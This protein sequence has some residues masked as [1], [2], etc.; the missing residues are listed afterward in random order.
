[1][2][3]PPSAK[4]NAPGASPGPVRTVI[5]WACATVATLVLAGLVVGRLASDRWQAT[6]YLH[7][8]PGV[9]ALATCAVALILSGAMRPGIRGS[10]GPGRSGGSRAL[11]RLRGALCGVLILGAAWIVL[12]EWHVLNA[13]RARGAPGPRISLVHFNASG[14]PAPA[15]PGGVLDLEPDVVVFTNLTH[16]AALPAV[17]QALATLPAGA[18]LVNA[19]CFTAVSRYPIIEFGDTTLGLDGQIF[20]N[21][22]MPLLRDTG[23]AAWFRIDTSAVLGREIVVWA[24]DFPSDLRLGRR[25]MMNAGAAAI[26]TWSGPTMIR[27]DGGNYVPRT[28]QLAGFPAPDIIIGDFNTPGGSVAIDEFARRAAGTGGALRDAHAAAGAGPDGTFPGF[29]PRWLAWG[30]DRALVRD[31]LDVLERSVRAVGGS[32]HRAQKVTVGVAAAPAASR[33]RPHP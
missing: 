1:V 27:Q 32:Q 33:T 21:R 28:S 7:W 18:S 29:V 6:Q 8:I 13:F 15:L 11:R 26:E 3:T 20:L 5:A 9:P 31:G 12:A 2:S 10:R 25:A 30:I 14:K 22:D 23:A 16:R 17:R 24:V 19:D 4:L